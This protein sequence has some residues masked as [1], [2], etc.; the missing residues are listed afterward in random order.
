LRDP[1]N[2]LVRNCLDHGIE[3][4]EQRSAAGKPTSGSLSVRV[5]QLSGGKIEIRIADD[6]HGID[7]DKLC[8]AALKSSVIIEAEANS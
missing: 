8:Q 4:P 3:S 5:Q 7:R 1:I 2:H 6:G